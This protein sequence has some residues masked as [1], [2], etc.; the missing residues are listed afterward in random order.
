MP[1][2]PRL[3]RPFAALLLAMLAVVSLGNPLCFA[4]D[5]PTPAPVPTTPSRQKVV[6]IIL[7]NHDKL[8]DTGKATGAYLS[9]V[10]HPYYAFLAAGCDVT[11]ASPKGGVAPLTGIEEAAKDPVSQRFLKDSAAMQALKVTRPISEV[12]AADYAAIFFPGGH[13]TMYDLP[14]AKELNAF[15]GRFYDAGGVV[16]AVCHGPAGL[17]NV[18]Q[19]N[20]SYLVAGKEVSCFTNEEET[21]VGLAQVMPFLLESKLIERG[22]KITKAGKFQKHVV[23][24]D[25]LVTGQN[26]A[27]AGSV[28]EE[29]L[30]LLKVK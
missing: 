19:A 4:A 11:F 29:V 13:G 24:A 21:A 6:L 20:G 1:R 23:V 5:V 9:E 18:K 15:T 3:L 10:S 26:P 25:R 17:I 28:A 8:G 12:K 27:S 7:T 30:K 16:S 14:D 2:T 22:A